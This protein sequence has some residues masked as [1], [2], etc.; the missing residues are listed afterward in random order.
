M[1]VEVAAHGFTV[2]EIARG[3]QGEVEV[4]R[5]S[6]LNRRIT[7][8]T[9]MTVRGPAT[10]HPLMRTGADPSG[11]RILG[12][13]N[14]C[15]G[16]V[17]PWG[18]IL[19]GEENIYN[20]FRGKAAD[21]SIGELHQRYGIAG[22][23]RYMSWGLYENRFDLAKEPHEPNRFGWIV[24]IDPHDPSSTPIKHTALGRFAHEGATVIL[25]KDGRPVAYTGDDARFE[26][27]YK[28]VA[29]DRYDPA[30]RAA[31]TAPG[32]RRSLRGQVP[33]RRHRRVAPARPGP[34]PL[35]RPTGS[36]RR[37]RWSST[38]AG[39]GISSARPR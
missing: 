35:R 33:R 10:G 25:A 31:A 39:R 37:P 12:T 1:D 18:T 8:A 3:P 14:N 26:Y 4:V 21:A 36:R 38:L 27:L 5:D 11:T 13:L 2:V 7:G 15:A 32:P 29:A 23:G 6:A 22:R 9:P 20:Y 34:G 16:G 17:T 30:N 28:F 19:T 24:E